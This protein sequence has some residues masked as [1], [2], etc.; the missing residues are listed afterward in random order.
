MVLSGHSAFGCTQKRASNLVLLLFSGVSCAPDAQL[1]VSR[2]R[3]VAVPWDF[4]A[5][6]SLCR[7]LLAVGAYNALMANGLTY[8]RT[9]VSPDATKQLAA[10][11]A[12]LL[13]A[14]DVILLSG[15]LGAGK[16]QFV[17]GVAAKLG[18]TG[19]VTSPTFNIM[20]AYE[21]ASLPLY[22]FDLYRLESPD[23]LEDIGYFE[24]L[25]G[26]GA[27]FVEWGDKFPDE[28]PYEYLEIDITVNEDETRTFRMHAY[29]DRPRR[30]LFLWAKDSRSRL[31]KDYS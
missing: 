2:Y 15:D 21:K 30:L 3:T 18:V 22:H 12:P 8:T 28:L 5:L 6:G 24:I 27:S 13:R 31:R 14:G 7:W 23:E 9:S 29:G 20:M 26:P 10:T 16:T 11:L 1:R 17:Q 19:A 25:D 4:G